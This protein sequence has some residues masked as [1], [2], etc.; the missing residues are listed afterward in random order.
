MMMSKILLVCLGACLLAST[1]LKADNPVFKDSIIIQASKDIQVMIIGE[2]LAD[3]LKYKRADSIKTLFLTD[4]RQ[5]REKGFG[6]NSRETHYIVHPSGKRRFKAESE[7]FQEPAFQLEKEKL[8]MSLN[9]PAAAYYLYD[10][11]TN[12]EIQ[13]F[14]SQPELLNELNDLRMDELIVLPV[15]DRYTIKRSTGITIK[16]TDNK[17]EVLWRQ[18]APK[19]QIELTSLFG[20]SLLGSK[21]SPEIGFRLALMRADKYGEPNW[22]VGLSYNINLLTTYTNKDFTDI[23]IVRSINAHWLMSRGGS[24]AAL[25]KWIGL[26]AGYVHLSP[27][28]LNNSLKLGFLT[29]YKSTQVGFHTYFLNHNNSGKVLYGVSFDF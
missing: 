4:W 10:V 1:P 20:A 6:G 28:I 2:D 29:T 25:W 23:Q 24:G 8:H 19:D 27:G 17:W 11:T 7:D 22:V 21:L 26:Q 14:V 18:W 15:A 3:L 12:V 9:L 16:K 13:I 5:A